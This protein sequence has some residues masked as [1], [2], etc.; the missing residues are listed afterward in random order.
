MPAAEIAGDRGLAYDLAGDP[1]QAQADYR[2]ALARSENPEVRRRLALSLGISGDRHEALATIDAQVRQ[3]DRAAWRT[4]AFVLA[5][6]GDTAGAAQAVQAVMPAQAAALQP[7]LARLPTLSVSDRALAVHFGHFPDDSAMVQ[8]PSA[9]APGIPAPIGDPTRAGQPDPAQPSLGVTASATGTPQPSGSQLVAVSLAQSAPPARAATAPV[10]PPAQ[11][12]QQPATGPPNLIADTSQIRPEPVP[13]APRAALQTSPAFPIPA[14][15]PSITGSQASLSTAITD[16]LTQSE[17]VTGPTASQA[18]P[19]S[20]AAPLETQ[21]TE[22]TIVS[23]ADVATLIA[24]LPAND[25]P[26]S[27]PPPSN[28]AKVAAPADP[29]PTRASAAL[30]KPAAQP[31]R[32]TRPRAPA[33]PKEPSRN[34]VQIAGGANEAALPREFTRLKAK[35]P[36]LFAGRTAWTTSLRATN[37]LLIGPF[38]TNREAQAF[39]SQLKAANL[40]GFAWTSAEGQEIKK[41]SVK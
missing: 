41:L 35:A 20:I 12:Q 32:S 39:V 17:E 13:A 31:A 6:T 36:K 4:R 21:P 15:A 40:A 23:F 37:R 27:A 3:Q 19:Q 2:L 9:T 25:E 34:W 38:K 30:A 1:R 8:A 16:G 24:A 11:Q 29:A 26:A 33:K 7:F 10:S 5:L 14:T 28:V 22:T 18:A